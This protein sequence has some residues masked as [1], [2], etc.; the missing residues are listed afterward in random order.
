R[1]AVSALELHP[2]QAGRQAAAVTPPAVIMRDGRHVVGEP[3]W[4]TWM[5]VGLASAAGRLRLQRAHVHRIVWQEA[6]AAAL[7]PAG[8]VRV[9][10]VR[11]DAL[12]GQLL[13]LDRKVCQLRMLD[14][15]V[16]IPVD[17]L[18]RLIVRADALQ[19]LNSLP[20]EDG[21]IAYLRLR[22]ASQSDASLFGGPLLLAGMR[23]DH[24]IAMHSRSWRHYAID[25]AFS[26]LVVDCGFDT[27]I[28][29][30]GEAVFLITGDN[31]ELQRLALSAEQAPRQL[32]V[33]VRGVQR[34]TLEVDFGPGGSS[35]DHCVWAGP[36]LL[37]EQQ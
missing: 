30:A 37:R 6:A 33:P 34:L 25:K 15:D 2:L 9:L 4:L 32:L 12:N 16:S 26:L 22:R 13:H 20:A 19:T 31:E 28:T 35:G 8:Q 7:P 5:E 18:V 1:N 27:S 10:T 24:G 17:E 3:E 29:K 36:L 14:Q 11:G 21:G 23:R